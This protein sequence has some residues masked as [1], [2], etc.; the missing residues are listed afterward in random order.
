MKFYSIGCSPSNGKDFVMNQMG[1]SEDCRS[2]R[3]FLKQPAHSGPPPCP[4]EYVAADDVTKAD[5]D[6]AIAVP[7]L[8]TIGFSKNFVT[9]HATTLS[10]IFEFIPC[11]FW[12]HD[13]SKSWPFFVV[14]FCIHTDFYDRDATRAYQRDTGSRAYIYKR[15]G[16][17]FDFAAHDRQRAHFVFTQKFRDLMRPLRAGLVMT[18]REVRVR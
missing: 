13:R 5:I 9:A 17:T 10:D 3:Q 1:S 8:Q 4:V 14:R 16:L 6:K 18:E 7:A 15:S 2:I 11:Q 12:Q